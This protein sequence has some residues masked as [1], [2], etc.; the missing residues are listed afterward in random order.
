[1]LTTRA[2]TRGRASGSYGA[3]GSGCASG[4]PAG[5]TAAENRLPG[6]AVNARVGSVAEV[7][8]YLDRGSAVCGDQVGVHL[9]IS[10]AHAPRT[11]Q[12]AA[13]RIGWYSGSGARLVW[14]SPAVT[15]RRQGTPSGAVA[16]HLVTPAW[17][18]SLT[19]SVDEGWPPGFY[20]LVPQ[21]VH[22]GGP[23]GPGV[24]LVVRDDAGSEPILFKA[25]TLTWNAYNEWGGWSLYRGP[26]GTHAQALADRAR[27]VAVHR[28]LTGSGYE[29]M[30]L[31]DL[32][33]VRSAEQ[34]GTRRG[35]DV[36]YTTDVA[37]DADPGQ[38][39]HHG[40]IVSGGHSEY[41]TTS[42]YD[43][44]LQALAGGV[45]A[46]FL[47]ANNLWWH[48]RLE[49]GTAP[50]EPDREVVYRTAAEDP[51]TAS[52]PSEA[53]VQWQAAPVRRDPAAVL[54][55]SHA[56][57]GVDGGLQLLNPPAWYTAGTGLGTGALLPDAVGNEADGFNPR[58]HNPAHT[59]VFAVGVLNGPNGAFL[60]TNSYSTQPSGAAVFA[61]GTTDWACA[62]TGT[63]GTHTI[64]AGTARVV[65]T[66]TQN[67]LVALASPRA[68]LT[69][70]ATL[71]R[72][73]AAAALIRL[74]PQ[75]TGSY[76]GADTDESAHRTRH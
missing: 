66:L 1:M 9:G 30:E 49:A 72:T 18:V 70:P 16:P 24:P 22:G 13:Y 26:G 29:Q 23:A 76:G 41:W 2:G 14:R 4:R 19:L 51:V 68:G 36:A 58:G 32:P 46:V 7:L 73:I 59:Q 64:P 35:I 74:P 34:V 3:A 15:V 65:S 45:N 28:P 75:A 61:A 38:L 6:V 27:V 20:L 37:V 43:G 50:G 10:A 40:E 54:G 53:T 71:T 60:V 63:C 5:W 25:S 48:T 8:G 44:L 52:N 31:M 56:G 33:V 11:V 57:I 67:V 21:E 47:G 55:Q 39:L 62:P 17:P 42:M 69:H 12:V